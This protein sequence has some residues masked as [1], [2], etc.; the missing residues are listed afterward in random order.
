[1]REKSFYNLITWS[2]FSL[3]SFFFK[4]TSLCK[5]WT[6]DQSHLCVMAV[7][8]L[9]WVNI[10]FV[11]I[12]SRHAT[13]KVLYWSMS[14]NIGLFQTQS[15]CHYN[16]A[17][18]G[19][20]S[21]RYQWRDWGAVIL[22]VSYCVKLCWCSC[23]STLACVYVCVCLCVCEWMF[24]RNIAKQSVWI[25]WE[26]KVGK[27]VQMVVLFGQKLKLMR[28]RHFYNE[29]S[30]NSLNSQSMYP[31]TL[32]LTVTKKKRRNVFFS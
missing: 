8:N 13:G 7:F 24:V 28:C 21:S 10:F 17:L 26:I 19:S 15:M 1:M 20:L 2:I 31:T 6:F 14:N 25:V 29:Q 4:K 12:D 30:N 22:T 18:I 32:G 11:V 16:M 9:I 27:Q 3:Q 5:V 23:L